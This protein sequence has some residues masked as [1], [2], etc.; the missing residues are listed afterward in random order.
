MAREE[1]ESVVSLMER[2]YRNAGGQSEGEL[3]RPGQPVL[4]DLADFLEAQ[5]E[6]HSA[7][8]SLWQAFKDRPTETSAELIGALEAFVEGKPDVGTRLNYLISEYD[9]VSTESSAAEVEE[10]RLENLPDA[11]DYEGTRPDVP[12]QVDEFYNGTYMYGNVRQGTESEGRQIGLN[13][14][15]AQD[16]INDAEEDDLLGMHIETEIG[17]FNRAYEAVQ[18]HPTLSAETRDH[19]NG[20]LEALERL[21]AQETGADKNAVNALLRNIQRLAPDIADML[22]S[23]PDFSDLIT[24]EDDDYLK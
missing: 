9:R 22:L 12:D 1:I 18:Q 10:D 23:E 4:D 5:F 7:Y 6:E 3:D 24:G 21:V 13:E 2:Y 11:D 14:R 16:A 15:D 20:D 19:V 17:I 8:L